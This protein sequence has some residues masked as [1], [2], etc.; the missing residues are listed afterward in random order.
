MRR[1]D[2]NELNLGLDP[3]PEASMPAQR[4]LMIS[5]STAKPLSP[6]QVEFNKRMKAL[7]KERAAHD[8]E[9]TRL[10]EDLRVCITELMPLV[11]T[12][13]RAELDLVRAAVEA[14]HSMKL[15]P[16]RHKWLGD[17]ISGKASTLFADSAGLSQQDIDYLD[18]LIEELGPNF[19]DEEQKE[20]ER[21][22]FDDIRE[23]M[24]EVARQAGVDL[25]LGGLD[26]HEDPAEFERQLHERLAAASEG[27]KKAANRE[28]L[29]P[30]R[31]R[32]P[33]KASLERERLAREAE[34][35]KTRDFKSL[36]KQLAKVLHPDLETDPVLKAHKE[37]WMKRLT[38]ARANGDLRDMLA[39]EMEWLGE[40][41]GNLAKAG[42][43]KLRIYSM[44]LKEQLADIKERTRM[45]FHEPQYQPL[46]RFLGPFGERRNPVVIKFGLSEETARLEEIAAVLRAGGKDARAIVHQWADA[47]A[48]ACRR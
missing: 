1:V 26:M 40:E 21:E 23:M 8:R 33:S 48:R 18:A 5:A 37:V 19:L 12:M 3:L 22:D 45:L 25:D 31:K 29:P 9:R 7:E 6:A 27:F 10:D 41:A 16:K 30:K 32:K 38:T 17:L 20:F 14:H 34:E 4:G 15:T 35:A 11:E 39:I 43:E 24:E 46:M 47:H 36:Y 13:N 44:V 42:D 2:Q 28:T